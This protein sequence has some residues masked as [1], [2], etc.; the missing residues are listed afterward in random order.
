MFAFAYMVAKCKD[1][2][3]SH[4]GAIRRLEALR[5]SMGFKRALEIPI[6][7][8][9]HGNQMLRE[10]AQY[11]TAALLNVVDEGPD[12][13]R[14]MI[15]PLTPFYTNIRS[16]LR[17]LNMAPVGFVVDYA[18][19]SMPALLSMPSLKPELE[20]IARFY[21]SAPKPHL[22]P[23]VAMLFGP[24]G[25][26]TNMKSFPTL[27]KIAFAAASAHTAS[28]SSYKGHSVSPAE[29][30]RYRLLKEA[31]D[32]FVLDADGRQLSAILNDTS[33]NDVHRKLLSD[34]MVEAFILLYINC[35]HLYANSN[36]I[37]TIRNQK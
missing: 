3:E 33:Q 10:M 19:T 6:G 15:A 11:R 18:L 32:G 22:Y 8:A 25:L 7:A 21:A 2:S 36:Q 1:D 34:M 12:G 26:D 17:F 31:Q 30:D 5:K 16:V 24:T 29:E 20:V 4:A 27:A 35:G 9:G 13:A 23:Y 37:V 28:L 14:K